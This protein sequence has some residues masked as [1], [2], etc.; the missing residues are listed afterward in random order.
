MILVLRATSPSPLSPAVT[1]VLLF[2]PAIVLSL[3][4]LIS[5]SVI[6]LIFFLTVCAIILSR[7][8]TETEKEGG[9]CYEKVSES[10]D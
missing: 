5:L 8:E 2:S 1:D 7:T 10:T 9:G 4:L 3:S 6:L